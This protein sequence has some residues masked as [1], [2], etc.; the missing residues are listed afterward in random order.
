MAEVVNMQDVRLAFAQ[1][2][3]GGQDPFTAWKT[4]AGAAAATA[5]WPYVRS[6]DL[7]S[8]FTLHV[9]TQGM[10]YNQPAHFKNAG[11]QA[12]TF[13]ITMDYTGAF[14]AYSAYNST[15]P[16]AMIELMDKL[17]PIPQSAF[18]LLMGVALPSVQ[19]TVNANANTITMQ[20][21]ALA[22]LKT[23]SGYIMT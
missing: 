12:I 1:A 7:T 17:S 5:I 13:N 6:F 11:N 20:G 10:G 16:M 14:P 9:V 19:F 3:G 15:V 8:A 2:S 18:T 21:Q 22:M 23:G 4:A